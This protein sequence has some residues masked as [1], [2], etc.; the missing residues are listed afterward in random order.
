[1][2]C[3]SGSNL[4]GVWADQASPGT[5]LMGQAWWAE[6]GALVA[7]DLTSGGERR[8]SVVELS[9]VRGLAGMPDGSLGVLVEG[10]LWVVDPM[11]GVVRETVALEVEGVGL[12]CAG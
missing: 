4:T 5:I 9:E 11:S 12:A 10:A 2:Q 8:L 1:M 7:L 3:G 6:D